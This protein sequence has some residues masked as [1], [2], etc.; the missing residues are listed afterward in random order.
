MRFKKIFLFIFSLFFI[1]GFFG[2]ELSIKKENILKTPFYSNEIDVSFCKFINDINEEYDQYEWVLPKIL[3]ERVSK[4]QKIQF[5]KKR[6]VISNKNDLNVFYSKILD[7]VKKQ[8]EY[9]E[10]NLDKIK[11]PVSKENNKIKKRGLRYKN[12]KIENIQKLR[13]N[14][15]NEEV[16][17]KISKQYI[18]YYKDNKIDFDQFLGFEFK[19][20]NQDNFIRLNVKKE[21]IDLEI[22]NIFN[23]LSIS[24]KEKK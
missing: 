4:I 7:K 14:F 12:K 3:R 5:Q 24:K 11:N 10:E 9:L 8:K 13:Y 16:K 23:S 2:K 18:Q 17:D 20:N 19:D 6:P 1:R 21:I 15:L 22:K